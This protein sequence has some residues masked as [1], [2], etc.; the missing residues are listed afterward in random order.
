MTTACGHMM[1]VHA[2]I[3]KDCATIRVII[4]VVR[5][6]CGLIFSVCFICSLRARVV[7]N[8]PLCDECE[9]IVLLVLI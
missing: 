3:W 9:L 5:S 1:R 8:V 4:V 6:G 7:L 2:Y